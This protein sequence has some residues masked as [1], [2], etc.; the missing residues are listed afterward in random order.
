M[1]H[2]VCED[3]EF[4][5]IK[6]TIDTEAKCNHCKRQREHHMQEDAK[7]KQTC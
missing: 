7:Q 2:D 3:S 6:V 1:N 5:L 4:K